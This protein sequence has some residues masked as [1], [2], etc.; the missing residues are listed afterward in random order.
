MK[1]GL[2]AVLLETSPNCGATAGAII[3]GRSRQYLSACL[4]YPDK[5][6]A[7]RLRALVL[8]L[9][10]SGRVSEML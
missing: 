2:A 3:E 4:T 9:R 1:H 8:L 7:V 10:Y 6:N 5:T